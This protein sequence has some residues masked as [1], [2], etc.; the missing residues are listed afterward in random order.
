MRTKPNSYL[1]SFLRGPLVREKQYASLVIPIYKHVDLDARIFDDT[2][3]NAQEIHAHLSFQTIIL[4]LIP[5]ILN[6][7]R[8]SKRNLKVLCH[9]FEVIHLLVSQYQ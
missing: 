5:L 8:A 7:R 4:A 3:K 2:V 1:F 9:N 6:F